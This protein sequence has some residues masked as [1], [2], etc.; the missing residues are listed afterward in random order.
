MTPLM[1]VS[2]LSVGVSIGFVV[3]GVFNS[4]DEET[5][6][7]LAIQPK[8]YSI[9]AAVKQ[10]SEAPPNVILVCSHAGLCPQTAGVP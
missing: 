3:A 6:H 5:E 9:S 1:S 7:G 10:I 2:L 4:R 8:S